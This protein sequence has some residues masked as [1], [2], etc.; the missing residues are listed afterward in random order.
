METTEKSVVEKLKT[1]ISKEILEKFPLNAVE[2][3]QFFPINIQNDFL[4]IGIVDAKNKDNVITIAKQYC[5]NDIKFISLQKEQFEELITFYNK[6]L[7]LEI[8][9]LVST[10]TPAYSPLIN[11]KQAVVKKKRLGDMLIE[12]GTITNEQLIQA[13]ADSKKMGLPIGS[14]LVKE[15]YITVE[16]LKTTL[17]QQ[18]GVGYL[19]G[20]MLKVQ[21]DVIELLPEDFMKSNKII[22]VS[23]D[24]KE[25]IVGMVNPHDKEVLNELIY[26]TGLQPKPMLIS[27]LEFDKYIETY[28]EAQA[29]TNKIIQAIEL[30]G[31]ISEHEDTL[32]EQVEK[33]LVSNSSVVSKFAN[34]IIT[35]AIDM[36]A[37]DVHIEP[38][39]T[40]YVVR[41]RI[42]GILKQ[43]IEIPEKI[44]SSL[45]SR[46]KVISR[47]NIAEHRRS[48]D[49]TFSLKYK[50]ISFDFRINT[51]PVGN[52]EKMVIRIL[53]P[54]VSLA[55]ADKEI[56][57]VG[58]DKGD[59][60]KINTMISAPNGIILT[61]GPTGSGKTTTLYSIIKN[62]NEED[63]NI[64]TIEDPIEIRLEGVNQTQVNPKA[65]ITF[66]S[67]MRAILRQD[68]DIILVGEIRDY[69][70][71]EAAISASLTGHLVLSTLHTNSA[72]ATITRLIEMGAK[73]YL[74]SSTLAGV[75][76]QRLVRR[77]CDDCK[78]SY[79]PDIK[80]LKSIMA[81]HEDIDTLMQEGS[82]Y[83][84][85]GCDKCGFTGY[86]G[87]LGVYEIMQINREIKKAIAQGSA[88][89]EIEELAVSCGMKTLNQ[90]C[91]EHILNGR[92]TIDEFIR[93]LGI[94]NE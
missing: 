60:E 69:E 22:P 12:A 20:N 10:A 28:F 4:Y 46:F 59:I 45:I 89:V 75:V 3:E 57:L 83:R 50:G 51:L 36:K 29:E 2:K 19:D 62:L 53:Q 40:K 77:L 80:K 92:T 43:V 35:D 23:N 88:D 39:L 9:K 84:S 42:D 76:A 24:G 81:S 90:A 72:A 66:A 79:I 94:V 61:V 13:L 86:K 49:G 55:A 68:P 5:T 91:L 15:G 38:R 18:Q 11:K 1:S 14:T 52:K 31:E 58:A 93:V 25:L 82:F 41:Y 44:E 54:A 33:E 71:L 70:T 27:H 47:M 64:T 7:L 32:W 8:D 37:S 56:K 65:D 30:E 78:E 74:I 87:R 48:Q 26:I 73:D 85:R 17:S 34:K 21:K 63:V 16:Q 67:C 6:S